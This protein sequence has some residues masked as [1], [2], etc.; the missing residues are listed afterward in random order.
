MNLTEYQNKA[1]ET[2]IYPNKTGM[3]AGIIYTALGL[4]SEA[5]E[6]SGKIKKIIRD[7]E[8]IINPSD[9]M[10]LLKELSDV[11]WYVSAASKELGYTLED[12]AKA[13]ISKLESRAKRGKLKGSGDSR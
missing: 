1:L 6:Y 5:G 4:A 11:L 10:E 3:N 7:K 13:N 9:R 12:V 2:A 8:G